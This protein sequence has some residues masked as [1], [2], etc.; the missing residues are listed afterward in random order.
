MGEVGYYRVD[1]CLAHYY[2]NTLLHNLW[3]LRLERYN[4]KGL[5]R[6]N[7]I[8]IAVIRSDTRGDDLSY[9]KSWTYN[10]RFRIWNRLKVSV[11]QCGS[12]HHRCSCFLDVWNIFL[13]RR[14][15]T[16]HRSYGSDVRVDR[17][18]KPNNFMLHFLAHRQLLNRKKWSRWRF[19]KWFL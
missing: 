4:E 13:A 2:S 8:N 15:L 19:I 14:V 17:L 3:W 11:L 7:N 6:Y 5:L 18:C 9:K 12:F 16:L 10:K 1:F